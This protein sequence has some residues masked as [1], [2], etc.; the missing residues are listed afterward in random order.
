M[1]V[2]KTTIG[3]IFKPKKPKYV[4]IS[5]LTNTPPAVDVIDGRK[6][7]ESHPTRR[8][9]TRQ[10]EKIDRIIIHQS[11]ADAKV[12]ALNEYHISPGNHISSDGLPHI[13]YHFVISREGVIWRCNNYADV[14]WHCKGVNTRSIG[15]CVVGNFSGPG[16]LG[17]DGPS[18]D[19][20]AALEYLQWFISDELQQ[21]FLLHGHMDYN[22]YA[23]PGYV[24]E[25]WVRE[26][27]GETLNV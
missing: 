25:R 5:V 22:K 14:T 26:T 17:S 27:R 7:L 19:Q 2:I 13:A 21:A 23:C 1:S 6:T 4:S 9:K 24:L 16:H 10:L 11:L 3:A 18:E 8:W 20:I 15:V 12:S